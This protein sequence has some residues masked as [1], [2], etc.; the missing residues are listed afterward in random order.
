VEKFQGEGVRKR[1][2]YH[3]RL[4]DTAKGR[5][6][7]TFRGGPRA[8]R[9]RKGDSCRNGFQLKEAEREKTRELAKLRKSPARHM[10]GNDDCCNWADIQQWKRH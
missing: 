5:E 3:A 4:G 2:F 8:S 7:H 10:V 9:G 1:I 6:V